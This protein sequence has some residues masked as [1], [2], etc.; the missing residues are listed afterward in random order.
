MPTTRVEVA[1]AVPVKIEQLG[2]HL[3]AY[4]SLQTT[5]NAL[6]LCNRFGSGTQATI[7]KL[8][9]EL[10]QQ[11]ERHMIEEKQEELMPAWTRDF[12]CWQN[13]CQPIDHMKDVEILEF[14]NEIQDAQ[15]EVDDC[16][17]CYTMKVAMRATDHVREFVAERLDEMS[18]DGEDGMWR[19]E[20][21][22]RIEAWHKRVGSPTN[23][24]RG[25]FDDFSKVLMKHFGLNVWITHVQES[26]ELEYA[27]ENTAYTTKAFLHLPQAASIQ[28]DFKPHVIDYA[29]S[30]TRRPTEAGFTSQISVPAPLPVKQVG[31]FVRVLKALN[32]DVDSMPKVADSADKDKGMSTGV[33][34]CGTTAAPLGAEVK[35]ELT[36]LVRNDDEDEW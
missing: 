26:R 9:I 1:W 8:P 24:S 27:N 6:R 21:D 30:G 17:C 16:G 31:R 18:D 4:T 36:I 28:Y 25:R 14:Y 22:D 35:P 23:P 20:H 2:A 13:V 15:S 10:V 34:V 19:G 29:W 5:L 33:E 7:T 3:E 32:I 12:R 11:I